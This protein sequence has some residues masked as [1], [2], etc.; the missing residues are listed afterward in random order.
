MNAEKKKP[1]EVY[2]SL[3]SASTAYT[4]DIRAG[5]LLSRIITR[6]K[7]RWTLKDGSIVMNK[8]EWLVD[9]GLSRHQYD[10]ARKILADRKLVEYSYTKRTKRSKHLSTCV[11]IPERTLSA[12]AD[13]MVAKSK[14]VK[15]DKT[16]KLSSDNADKKKSGKSVSAEQT[17]SEIS[18]HAEDIND[19]LDKKNE[20]KKS[21]D[22]THNVVLEKTNQ[23]VEMLFN[24]L[25]ENKGVEELEDK[26]LKEILDFIFSQC[27]YSPDHYTKNNLQKMKQCLSY[28]QTEEFPVNC[29]GHKSSELTGVRCI[30][31]LGATIRMWPLFMKF[32]EYSAGA[33]K[34]PAR[35]TFIRLHLN[36]VDIPEFFRFQNWLY[37]EVDWPDDLIWG[38]GAV[39]HYTEREIV[40]IFHHPYIDKQ[41]SLDVLLEKITDD[42]FQFK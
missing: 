6:T 18:A 11:K 19:E 22:E 42:E 27:T 23:P 31:A 9:T 30:D 12:I 16:S 5:V 36:Y 17:T 40:Y 21:N 37:N 38:T 29:M 33:F 34:I 20:K 26:D 14:S 13:I 15:T 3:I 41:A 24:S 28:L 2:P 1:F 35:P 4:G 39:D 32:I 25:K 8:N 7:K 10:K